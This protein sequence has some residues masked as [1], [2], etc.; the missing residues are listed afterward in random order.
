ML[1]LYLTMSRGNSLKNIAL[2][3]IISHGKMY[4]NTTLLYKRVPQLNPFGAYV[5]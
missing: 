2:N 1:D 4:K 5:N 3:I